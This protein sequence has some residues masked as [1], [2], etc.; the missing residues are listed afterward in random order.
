MRHVISTRKGM[1]SGAFVMILFS[2]SIVGCKKES[3]EE[4]TKL[5]IKDIHKDPLFQD[6]V[7]KIQIQYNAVQD[8]TQLASI[9]KDGKISN[10]EAN[11]MY[12]VYGYN[13]NEE[14]R[15]AYIQLAKIM[16][17]L[18]KKYDFNAYTNEEKK[19]AVLKTFEQISN[20]NKFHSKPVILNFIFDDC[21]KIRVNCILSVAAEATIMHL[22]CAAL[23]VTFIFGIL[24]H[25]T[26]ILY[27]KTAGDNCNL[28]AN[29]CKTT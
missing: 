21:E 18:W 14:F 17:Q 19:A 6:Y 26:S 3:T 4:I 9:I 1:L 23:D 7:S 24:C 28:A 20:K 16:R 25:G 15:F 27:Q 22:G 11:L 13:N 2:L 12:K 29:K 8:Y 10:E 5:S